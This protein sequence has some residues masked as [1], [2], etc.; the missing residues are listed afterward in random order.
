MVWSRAAVLG[1]LGGLSA[2]H[3]R[4]LYPAHRPP[5]TGRDLGYVPPTLCYSDS[6]FSRRFLSPRA[7][8]ALRAISLRSSGVSFS[9]RAFPPFKP[10]KASVGATPFIPF[11]SNSLPPAEDSV[12][13]RMYHYFMFNREEFLTPNS[14]PPPL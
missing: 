12:W 3:E 7:L 11:K 8:A 2:N 6:S 1:R 5:F 9:A 4:V 10:P 14:L 13:S